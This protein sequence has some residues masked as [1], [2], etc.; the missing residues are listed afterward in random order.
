MN[1]LSK[2]AFAVVFAACA[3]S[4]ASAQDS[5]VAAAHDALPQEYKSAGVIKV[6][7][8]IS[9]SFFPFEFY[10][11][12][13]KTA[14]GFDIDIQNAIGQRLGVRVQTIDVTFDSLITALQSRRIDMIASGM[15]DR[16]SRHAIVR[17]VDYGKAA[18]GVL[19]RRADE[20]MT[21]FAQLCGKKLI[22]LNGSS[23]INVV[24]GKNEE[25]GKAGKPAIELIVL[26]SARDAV[27]AVQSRRADAYIEHAFAFL[28]APA[29]LT[30]SVLE[31]EGLGSKLGLGVRTQEQELANAVKIAVQ[32]MM[33]DGA[34]GKLLEK[35]KIPSVGIGEA[36]INKPDF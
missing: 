5:V 27:L 31:D 23:Y 28:N 30:S 4:A 18:P 32:S 8:D 9:A 12:D 33:D 10:A 24:D 14:Q 2:Y 35:W 26:E 7:S 13:G 6:G 29:D 22:A 19:Q 34:Y 11:E 17:F 36:T 21:R 1:R 3:A 25:C 20:V 16:E 15:S